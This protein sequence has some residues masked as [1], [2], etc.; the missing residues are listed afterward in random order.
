[1]SPTWSPDGASIAFEERTGDITSTWMLALRTHALHRLE[2]HRGPPGP[3]AW[4]P[5]GRWLAFTTSR[6]APGGAL[7]T[8]HA[9]DTRG[10]RVVKVASA[11]VQQLDGLAWR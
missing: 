1:V 5:E 6:R 10:G 9:V 4:S 3:L 8:V 7:V 11:F 2:R